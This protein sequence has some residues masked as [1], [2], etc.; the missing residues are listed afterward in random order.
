MSL[1]LFRTVLCFNLDLIL[2]LDSTSLRSMLFLL[3]RPFS[4]EEPG[5]RRARE[6]KS[7]ILSRARLGVVDVVG[8]A[9]KSESSSEGIEGGISGDES[10]G[11]VGTRA[12]R[13]RSRAAGVSVGKGVV[14]ETG[15]LAAE[16]GGKL[17][18]EEIFGV[19]KARSS[20]SWS[21][22]ASTT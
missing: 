3:T 4:G 5:S 12:K 21:S 19:D 7:L 9:S 16:M 6:N 1:K 17:D 11:W 2:G 13:A 10:P 22:L 15:W 8:G 18:R 20:S 14:K